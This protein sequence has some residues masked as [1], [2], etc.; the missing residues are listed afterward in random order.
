MLSDNVLDAD[1][2]N[3]GQVFFDLAPLIGYTI[4]LLI[5]NGKSPEIVLSELVDSLM[6]AAPGRRR[7]HCYLLMLIDIVGAVGQ[8]EVCRAFDEEVQFASLVAVDRRHLSSELARGVY[9][10]DSGVEPEAL[11]VV[12]HAVG[13][14]QQSALCLVACYL[15]FQSSPVFFQKL[16]GSHGVHDN[17]QIEYPAGLLGHY[18][19]RNNVVEPFLNVDLCYRQHI[20]CDKPRFG[21]AEGV[22]SSHRLSVVEMLDK[23]VAFIELLSSMCKRKRHR[24]G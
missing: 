5:G 16:R 18:L 22:N 10:F 11:V 12:A 21:D 15:N 9:A 2:G 3:E 13:H 17:G 7:N 1:Y 24:K 23:Y 19:A 8:Q 6:Y 20:L 14:L 4:D